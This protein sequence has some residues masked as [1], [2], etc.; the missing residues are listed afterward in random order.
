MSA[1][2]ISAAPEGVT[3][4]RSGCEPRATR[5]ATALGIRGAVGQQRRRERARDRALAGARRAVE[6]VGVRGSPRGGSA[7]AEHRARV[8][9]R[10]DARQR[11]GS[12]SAGAAAIGIGRRHGGHR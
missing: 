8:R 12:E 5:S 2:S 1:T 4:V 3:Q 7:G 11:R 9:V 10:V 6:Q